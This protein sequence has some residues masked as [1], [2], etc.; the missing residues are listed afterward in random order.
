MID[1]FI[2]KL[3]DTVPTVGC[4]RV[5][6]C[7]H[8]AASLRAHLMFYVLI[9]VKLSARLCLN[10]EFQFQFLWCSVFWD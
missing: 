9:K 3:I 5:S 7:L 4:P 6:H 2:C 10:L 8:L 1:T